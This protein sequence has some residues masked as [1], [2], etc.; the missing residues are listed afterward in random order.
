M[1]DSLLHSLQYFQYF[2]ENTSKRRQHRGNVE[3]MEREITDAVNE[4]ED[5]KEE[6]D[7][8]LILNENK[9]ETDGQLILDKN[10]EEADD[11]LILIEMKEETDD[12]LMDKILKRLMNKMYL[13]VMDD[14]WSNDVWDVMSRTFPDDNNG[15]R[16]ILTSRL[17]EV[18]PPELEFIR[19][20][21]AGR[22]QRLPLALL[23]VAGHL[24]KI[25]RTQE[26]WE[27]VSKNVSK[28]VATESDE[29]LGLLAMSYNYLPNHLKSCFLYMG[30]FPEDKE[31]NIGTLI[32][33]WV[34]EGFVTKDPSAN[35]LRVRRYS[36][37]SAADCLESSSNDLTQTVH[38]FRGLDS[39]QVPLL[40]R[41]KLLRVLAII[42]YV[43]EDFPL[44]ITKL[45]HLRY[46]QLGHCGDPHSSLSELYN[47]KIFIIRIL[48]YKPPSVHETNL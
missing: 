33:L 16:I 9:E 30:V 44:V 10:G 36:F 48:G 13:I 41:F 12:E 22:C 31:V 7:D 27:D 40:A 43:F 3:E 38:F 39:K 4:T 17:K 46:L 23:V 32:S 15:S 14:I 45:V 6:T 29:C 34:S 25:E 1:V 20:Q 35:M 37:H 47:L 26:S 5:I 8:Q 28:V 42:Q 24:S 21:V 2:L 11:E 19:K 18:C